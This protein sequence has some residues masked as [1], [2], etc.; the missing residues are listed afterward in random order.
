MNIKTLKVKTQKII[1]Y[2][3]GT[4]KQTEKYINLGYLP[5]E[6]VS[7]DKDRKSVV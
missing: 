6:E 7:L 4:N 5:H 3:Q 2:E 1:Q